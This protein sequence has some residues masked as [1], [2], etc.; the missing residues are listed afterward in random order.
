MDAYTNRGTAYSDLGEY[1]K[2][3]FNYNKAIELDP[4]NQ[5]AINNKSIWL[6][7]HPELDG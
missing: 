7:D 2:A 1:E 3:I 4:Y 5:T 6:Q